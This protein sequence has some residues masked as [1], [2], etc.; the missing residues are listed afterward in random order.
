MSRLLRSH[1]EV[2]GLERKCRA[3]IKCREKAQD[4]WVGCDVANS[5]IVLPGILYAKTVELAGTPSLPVVPG[6]EI[7][8]KPLDLFVNVAIGKVEDRVSLPIQISRQ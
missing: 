8:L 1:G 4:Y 2:Q 3:A 6:L 5:R 7:P